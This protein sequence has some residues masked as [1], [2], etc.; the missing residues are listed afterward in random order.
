MALGEGL[1]RIFD[2]V[3]VAANAA[4]NLGG[5]GAFGMTVVALYG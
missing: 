5:S 2:I 4:I 1:S 3:P